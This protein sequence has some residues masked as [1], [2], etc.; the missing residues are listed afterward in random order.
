MW[1]WVDM[2]PWGGREV[3]TWTTGELEHPNEVTGKY[4]QALG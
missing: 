2:Q 3:L 1:T 4:W